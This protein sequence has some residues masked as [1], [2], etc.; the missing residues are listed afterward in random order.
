MVNNGI[1]FEWSRVMSG[2][3]QGSVL[4]LILFT[5]FIKDIEVGINIQFSVF[6]DYTKLGRGLTPQQDLIALQEDLLRIEQ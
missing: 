2:V 4:G 6:I 1:S 5:L 3:P